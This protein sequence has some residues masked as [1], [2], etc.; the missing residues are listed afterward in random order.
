MYTKIIAMY[1]DKAFTCLQKKFIYIK[2]DVHN[3]KMKYSYTSQ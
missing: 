3:M 2:T 1:S